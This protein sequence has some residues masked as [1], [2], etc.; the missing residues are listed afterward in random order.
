MKNILSLVFIFF[1]SSAFMACT[2][3]AEIS[4]AAASAENQTATA[5]TVSGTVTDSRGN[6]LAGVQITIE[7]TVWQGTYV[8]AVTNS[9]GKYKITIPVNPAGSW[10]AK[11][12]L[13]KKAYGQQYVFDLDGN[14]APFTQTQS[15]TRNFTWKLSGQK[16]GTDSYYGAHVDL[17]QW[18]T[19]ANMTKVKVV[20]TPIADTLI[21]GSPAI[22][23]ERLV[24][25]V[26]GTFMAKDVPIG[27][28]MIKAKYPGKILYLD[29]RHNSGNPK[30]S[31]QVIFGKYGFLA[32]TEYNIE[33]WLSE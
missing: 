28:Y 23:F 11:A 24:E 18:G 8:R 6:P 17:Y 12:K 25:D 29:N 26:A 3:N 14:S 21:D 19:D 5:K 1:F 2:K 16:P 30:V 31:K 13:T 4:H 15:V 9:K 22:S 33:F 32:E 20:F 27:K 7:H 10:T